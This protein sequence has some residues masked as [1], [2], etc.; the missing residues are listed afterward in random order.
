MVFKHWIHDLPSLDKAV[1][2]IGTFDGIH[3]GHR[4][5]LEE[6]QRESKDLTIDNDDPVPLILISF[7]RHPLELIAPDRA[8]KY[9]D[10]PNKKQSLMEKFDLDYLVLLKFDRILAQTPHYEFINALKSKF[11]YFVLVQGFNF[12]FGHRNK[13]NTCWLAE[14]AQKYPE[15]FQFVECDP[16]TYHDE[17]ISSTRIRQAIVD[18]KMDDVTSMLDRPYRMW[19]E[20]IYGDRFGTEINFPTANMAVDIQQLPKHGVYATNLH[21]RGRV[22]QSMTFVGRKSKE[23]SRDGSP[24]I[25]VETNAFDFPKMDIYGEEIAVDFIKFIRGEINFSNF[26]ELKSQLIKDK[27][28]CVDIFQPLLVF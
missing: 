4:Y 5:V 25:I 22:Y 10:L 12:Q 20:V 24:K 17:P 6:M 3:K 21:F 15:K 27:A 9:I 8:P 7:F 14:E 23:L 13:G 16:V 11:N 18:G 19:G 28:K 2:T 26:D 1:I